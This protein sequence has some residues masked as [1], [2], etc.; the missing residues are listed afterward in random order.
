MRKL[1]I[2]SLM[3]PAWSV[4]SLTPVL[5]SIRGA[6]TAARTR[7]ASSSVRPR[8]RGDTD[9]AELALLAEPVLDGRRRDAPRIS[10]HQ[11]TRGT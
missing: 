9:L 8:G 2:A 6:P 3:S 1:P 4:A 11:S 5:T 7:A 10:R